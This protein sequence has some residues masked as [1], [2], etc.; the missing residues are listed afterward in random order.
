[1]LPLEPAV[2][3]YG[4]LHYLLA[5]SHPFSYILKT[6]LQSKWIKAACSSSPPTPSFSKSD[7][8]LAGFLLD[9]TM[10]LSALTDV[11]VTSPLELNTVATANH[12]LLSSLLSPAF[13][14]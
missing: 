11:H 7:I 1:M 6:V 14:A 4:G 12:S 5:T 13:R 2:T 8:L 10:V 3:C 9:Q